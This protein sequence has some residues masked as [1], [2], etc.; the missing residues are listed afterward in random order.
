MFNKYDYKLDPTF[1][2][3][4]EIKKTAKDP[5]KC[6]WYYIPLVYE[7]RPDLIAYSLYKDVSMAEYLAII[8]DID[9]TPD[10]FYRDRKIKVLKEE[11]KDLVC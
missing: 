8:N 10:G 6:E 9:N 2:N 1:I 7:F 4:E 3:I 5:D 11:Y